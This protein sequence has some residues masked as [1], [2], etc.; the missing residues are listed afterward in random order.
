M[1]KEFT[2]SLCKQDLYILVQADKPITKLCHAGKT[3]KSFY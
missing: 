1:A 2:R 3:W